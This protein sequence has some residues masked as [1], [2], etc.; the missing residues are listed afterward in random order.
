M[1]GGGGANMGRSR[2]SRMG[3]QVLGAN[4]GHVERWIME[5]NLGNAGFEG[6]MGMSCGPNMSWSRGEAYMVS[7]LKSFVIQIPLYERAVMTKPRRVPRRNV[8]AGRK[9]HTNSNYC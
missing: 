9:P 3:R 4:I 2:V 8:Y 6:N 5:W 1:F 7:A